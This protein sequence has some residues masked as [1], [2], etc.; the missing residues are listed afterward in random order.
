MAVLERERIEEIVLPR[1]G[2]SETSKS[3]GWI[4]ALAILALAAV[5]VV[6]GFTVAG[7][8]T[9]QLSEAT[10]TLLTPE[11]QALVR[12]ANQGYV[13]NEA[14]DWETIN[15]KLLVN[16]GVVPA[17]T[18]E[19]YAPAPAPLVTPA[20]SAL[21]DAVTKGIVP[22]QALDQ[23]LITTKQLINQG[24]IPRGSS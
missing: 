13:P 12:L 15:T 17:E 3:Y 23:E 6:I 4:M 10:A 18:L 9:A 21:M 8:G 1:G 16:Q 24:L 20:A 11:E 19:P 22:E 2:T 5:A 7:G 14:I